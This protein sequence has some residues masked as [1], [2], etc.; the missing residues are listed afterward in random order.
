MLAL[1]GQNEELA[2]RPKSGLHAAMPRH[3]HLRDAGEHAAHRVSE[4]ELF[5]DLVFVFAVTQ[6]SHYLLDHHTLAGALETLSMFLA[7]WWAW[8]YTAWATNWLDPDRPPVRLKLTIVM[9][10]SLVLSSAIPGAFGD[11]GLHFALAY[12]AIQ[13]G[14]TAYTAW[15]KGEWVRGGSKNLTRATLYFIVSAPL[16]IS[17]GLDPD[18]TLRLAWWAAA[19]VVDYAGPLLFFAVPGLGRSQ[20]QE[21]T[22]SG[23]HMAERCA[24]FIIISLGEGILVTGATFAKLEPSWPAILAFLSAFLG[25]VAMW[26]I[27]FDVGARRGSA[28]IEHDRTP[29]LIG[30]AAYTYGHIPIVAGIIVLAVADEQVLTH[31][32]G[33][34]APLLISSLLG[35]AFLFIGGTMAF[36]W[37]TSGQGLWPLSHLVG[38]GLFALHGL[39]ALAVH[40]PPL[41]LHAVTTVVFVVIAVWEWGSF[42]GGWVE[43]WARLRT[44]KRKTR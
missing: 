20:P 33:Q 10:L 3:S 37:L 11:Y 1:G 39:W 2:D 34:S 27:Y 29:G 17:G 24:L 4:M 32:T 43:R 36:K 15:A 14:R 12:V 8:V 16:W 35:G 6:L 18:P 28:L 23:A 9:L 13:I 22:I 21:W 19:L 5:F 30:R 38:L 42:H 26:W 7:V 44:A 41:L 31:P 40:P 25:S